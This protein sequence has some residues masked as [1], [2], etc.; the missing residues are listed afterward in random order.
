MRALLTSLLLFAT[1]LCLAQGFTPAPAPGLGGAT[2]PAFLPV[3]EA[4]ELAVAI[5]EEGSLRLQWSNTEGYYLYRHRF[6][7]TLEDETGPVELEVELPPGLGLSDEF[8][9]DVEVY[10]WDSADIRV[11]PQRAVGVGRLAVTYQGCADMGLCY[12]PETRHFSVD[13]DRGIV[14]PAAAC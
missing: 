13:F 2:Q 4:Y 9:G 10:Y 1:S 8:F 5:E 14:T 7:F 11:T 12:P 3:D 6:A